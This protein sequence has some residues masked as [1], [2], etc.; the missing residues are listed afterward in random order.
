MPATANPN[1]NSFAT[2]SALQNNLTNGSLAGSGLLS[3]T[4][5]VDYYKFTLNGSSNNLKLE[6]QGLTGNAQLALYKATSPTAI[7]TE[8]NRISLPESNTGTLADSYTGPLS[9]LT[10]GT[11]YIRVDRQDNVRNT[12]TTPETQAE[13]AL[14]LFVSS[15]VDATAFL[16][17]GTLP[18]DN[19]FT[20]QMNGTTLNRT[21]AYAIDPSYK[22]VGSGDFDGDGTSDILWRADQGDNRV[23]IW[24][25]DGVALVADPRVTDSLGN[26]VQVGQEWRIVGVKDLDGNSASDVLWRSTSGDVVFWSIQGSTITS[27]SNLA[28][29]D[30]NWDLVGLENMDGQLGADAIWRNR[31]TNQIEIETV[32]AQRATLTVAPPQD[33]QILGVKDFSGDGKA[34]ILWRNESLNEVYLWRM[35]GLGDPEATRTISG[36]A[37]SYKVAAIADFNGDNRADILW[38]NGPLAQTIL[39]SMTGDGLTFSNITGEVSAVSGTIPLAGDTFTVMGAT[40]LNADRKAD[41]IWRNRQDGQVYVWLMDGKTY[42]ENKALEIGGEALKIP[43]AYQFTNISYGAYSE[44]NYLRAQQQRVT[45]STAGTNTLNAFDLGKLGVRNSQGTYTDSLRSSN[46]TDF[47]KFTIDGSPI[48]FN[49]GL[50]LGNPMKVDLFK[51]SLAT[52]ISYTAGNDLV[53]DQ[54]GTYFIRVTSTGNLTSTAVP[55]TLNLKADLPI[56]NLLGVGFTAPTTLELP[57]APQLGTVPITFTVKNEGNIKAGSFNVRFYLSSDNVISNQTNPSDLQLGQVVT[58][59][60]GLNAN[61]TRDITVN[62]T[63][64][65]GDNSDTTKFWLTDRDYYIGAIIEALPN[66]SNKDD[67]RNLGAGLD[68]ATIAVTNVQTS[69]LSGRTLTVVNPAPVYSAGSSVT[70][71]YEVQNTGR[72]ATGLPVKLRFILSGDPRIDQLA[73]SAGGDALLNETPL[74]PMAAATSANAPFIVGATGLVL[75]LPGANESFWRRITPNENGTATLYIGT[76]IDWDDSIISEPN[77]E[78]NWNNTDSTETL[79]KNLVA[80]TVTVPPQQD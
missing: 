28:T 33:Y 32:G 48:L 16:W 34:D 23:I 42:T 79:G 69:E 76:A 44:V 38:R 14:S 61:S 55:Y 51:D 10:A 7:P 56:V 15:Q 13:Y 9:N 19:T 4:D 53:L 59:A 12:V 22:I 43:E 3:A 24:K 25:T 21:Q 26:E 50:G 2:A 37:A 35:N 74:Q 58:I 45:Q 41:I 40:D 65:V 75:T 66:E 6:L 31:T 73:L 72:R 46:A 57:L 17:R 60:D 11:Y 1:N 54:N 62:L 68:L 52:Q 27:A 47:Y 18:G 39:W 36:V 70:V 29:R 67:N 77:E 78:N 30:S 8:A 71:N 5:T 49:M 63:L 80:I 20:W 64:P